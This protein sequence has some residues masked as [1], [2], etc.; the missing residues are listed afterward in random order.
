MYLNISAELLFDFLI[1]NNRLLIYV[2]IDHTERL[3]I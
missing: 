1:D 2:T 3:K